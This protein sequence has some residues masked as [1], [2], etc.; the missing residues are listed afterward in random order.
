MTSWGALTE[1]DQKFLEAMDDA[2]KIKTA[3][4]GDPWIKLSA[5]GST[6]ANGWI[7]IVAVKLIKHRLVERQFMANRK[8]SRNDPVRF[9]YRLTGAGRLQVQIQRS[10]RSLKKEEKGEQSPQVKSAGVSD[11]AAPGGQSGPLDPADR[12]QRRRLPTV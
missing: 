10:Q 12:M 6:K 5:M 1:R 3:A 8:Y 4:G 2:S 11:A 7:A 9:E